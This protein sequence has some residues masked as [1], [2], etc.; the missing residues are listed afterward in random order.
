MATYDPIAQTKFCKRCGNRK[1][2][3]E[4]S[5]YRPGR[6]DPYDWKCA[7]CGREIS[8]EYWNN[9]DNRERQKQ[10]CMTPERRAAA[11]ERKRRYNATPEAKAKAS[12]YISRPEVKARYLAHGRR[13]TKTEKGALASKAKNHRRR[14]MELSAVGKFTRTDIEVRYK[15][16]RG[17]CAACRAPLKKKY[18]VDHIVSLKRGGTNHP[19]NLQL[20]CPFCNMSKHDRDPIEFMQSLGR[21]L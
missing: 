11:I 13:W 5:L 10:Q 16:Q 3:T 21:L 19:R 2:V 9:P 14:A 6:T 8:R 20:L 18:H 4:F 12:Q 17:K 7:E 15:A 1:P